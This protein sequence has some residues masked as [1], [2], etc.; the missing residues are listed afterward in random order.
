MSDQPWTAS[1]PDDVRERVFAAMRDISDRAV[2]FANQAE[3]LRTPHGW[4]SIGGADFDYRLQSESLYEYLSGLRRGGNPEAALARAQEA[5]RDMVKKWNENESR[6][7]VSVRGRH[8][9]QRWSDSAFSVIDWAH[10]L[11]HHA[12][13]GN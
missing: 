3:K 2:R 5:S 13:K 1:L 12:V 10:R 4:T 11:V 9:L 6:G 7:R 8:E